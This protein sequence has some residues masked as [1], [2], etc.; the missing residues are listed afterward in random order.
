M[1]VGLATFFSRS[2]VTAFVP[3]ELPIVI[4]YGLND[5]HSRSWVRENDDGVVG[6]CY[7]QR[8]AGNYTDGTLLY[9]TIAPNGSEHIDSVTTGTRME[10]SVLLYD[11]LSEPHI[12]MARSN[13]FDQIIEHYFR[14][15]TGQWQSDTIMHFYGEG[16]KFIYEMSAEP[17]PDYSFHL[18]VL[19]TRSDIDSDDFMDAW[20]NSFLYHV[21]NATG[22]WQKE[23]IQNYDMAFTY[24]MYIKTSC[25]QDIKVDR[26]GYVHVTF[27]E[28]IYGGTYPSRL[29]YAT[30]KTGTWQIEVALNYEPGSTDDAGW[31]PSLCFDTNDVPYIACDYIDRVPTYSAYLWKLLLLKRIGDGSWT[32]E[33]V[34]TQ[35]DGYSGG[36]GTQFT[37]GLAHLVFDRSNTPHIVFSDIASTHWPIRNQCV[38]V[39]N[40]RY[41]VRAG[42]TWDI[43]TIYRQPLPTGFYNATEMLEL[44]LNI[45]KRTD[46]MRVIGVE[47]VVT[48][49][50]EYTTSLL[51]F[52]WGV[53]CCTGTT[54]NVNAEGIVDLADLSALVSYLTGGGYVLPCP[55]EANINVTGIVDLSDLTALVSYLTVGTYVLPPCPQESLTP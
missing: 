18:L 46:T 49:E 27:A 6:I 47:L 14:R 16:G 30:N 53:P 52:A 4:H 38:N 25:R 29:L 28:Q 17:G 15:D 51:E 45:P 35:S 37:G 34:A 9:R 19:K 20:I 13:E 55:A 50:Y 33:V 24:D 21:T 2:A 12:F 41:A 3:A 11:S 39:G 31:F 32:S 43:R 22:N 8:F 5:S 1:I 40:I 7:F 48:G 10:K 26:D 42:A 23:L 36:D 54:G 44:C